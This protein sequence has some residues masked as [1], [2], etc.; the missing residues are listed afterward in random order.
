MMETY[1]VSDR[2]ITAKIAGLSEEELKV[3][4]ERRRSGR[5][6][7]APST[8]ATPRASFMHAVGGK[9]SHGRLTTEDV[10]VDPVSK[11]ADSAALSAPAAGTVGLAPFGMEFTGD[12][13]CSLQNA[14]A[15]EEDGTVKINFGDEP[16]TAALV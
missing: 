11:A 4:S 8:L 14:Q 16:P 12:S 15:V 5:S 10:G 2:V 13:S 9:V 1:W 7:L 6:V 3:E